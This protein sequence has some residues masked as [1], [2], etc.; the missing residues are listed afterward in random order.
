MSDERTTETAG[1]A[2]IKWPM[3]FRLTKN[4][5]AHDEELSVLVLRMPEGKDVF[6]FGLLDGLDREQF[7]PLVSALA[8]VPPRTVEAMAAEDILKLAT[9]LTRFF[10]Q[11]ATE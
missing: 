9:R 10:I 6:K 8:G 3:E 4:I 7:L 2:P 5:T 1:P 11:A